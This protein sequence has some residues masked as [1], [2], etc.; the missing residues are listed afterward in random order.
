MVGVVDLADE[1]RQRELDLARLRT[2]RLVVGHEPEP[3]RQEG[4]DVRGL[5]YDDLADLHARRRKRQCARLLAVEE[6]HH[7]GHS[8][9]PLTRNVDVAGAGVLEQ[10]PDELTASLNARPIVEIDR[11]S[12]FLHSHLAVLAGFYQNVAV[13]AAVTAFLST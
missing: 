10:Q 12:A 2:E 11:N 7:G 6:A 3:R 5:R 1:V 4:E 9:L 13:G 8:V